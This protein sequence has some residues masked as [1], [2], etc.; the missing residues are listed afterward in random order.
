MADVRDLSFEYA[1]LAVQGP[2]AEKVLAPHT[3]FDLSGIKYYHFKAID[4][5]NESMLVSR[6]GYTGEDGFEMYMEP[7]LAVK[8]WKVLFDAAKRAGIEVLPCGLGARDTLRLEAGYPLYGCELGEDVTPIEAGL[9]RF[10]S[11][12]KGDF[13]GRDALLRQSGEGAGKTLVGFEMAEDGI[14]RQGCAIVRDGRAVGRVTSGTFS[15]SLGRPIGMGYVEAAGTGNEPGAGLSI[16]IRG[17]ARR[18]RI[19]KRPFYRRKQPA[20]TS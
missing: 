19:V 9:G 20:G 5:C 7:A 3:D 15:P 14:A 11:F 8:V 12:D 1:Q 16:E 6:T 13:I 4:V 18:A 10:V 2:L 17:R